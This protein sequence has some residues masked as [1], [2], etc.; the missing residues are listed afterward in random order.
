MAYAGISN[1]DTTRMTY[2]TSMKYTFPNATNAG[3]NATRQTVTSNLH[4]VNEDTYDLSSDNYKLNGNL[5]SSPNS[6][7][8]E[9]KLKQ[10]QISN[11]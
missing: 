11:I 8:M 6:L 9:W 3:S 2:T 10:Y 1:I 4:Y 7:S 5:Y